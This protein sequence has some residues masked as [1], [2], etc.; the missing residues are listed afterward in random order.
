M[1]SLTYIIIKFEFRTREWNGGSEPGEW[2]NGNGQ[3]LVKMY[4][5]SAI[6]K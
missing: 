1:I 4:K 5:L 6:N 2:I 3:M